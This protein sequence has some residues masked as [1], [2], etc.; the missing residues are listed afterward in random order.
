MSTAS[1]TSTERATAPRPLRL[2]PLGDSITDG[3][4]RL[5]SY[6]YHLYR[7]LAASAHAQTM[8]VGSM[9]GVYDKSSGRNATSGRLVRARDD[10]PVEAQAHEG[11]WGWT[12]RD[13]LLGHPRQPHRGKLSRW[14]QAL[15][16]RRL[17]ADIA[18]VHLG[19]NDLTKLT[20]KHG[21][22]V[23]STARRLKFVVQMLC[24]ASPRVKIALASPIPYCHFA[25]VASR[26]EAQRR[27]RRALEAELGD[28]IRAIVSPAGRP[29]GCARARL[30]YVNMSAAVGCDGLTADRVHPAESG[31]KLM[32]AAWYGAIEPMLAARRTAGA[33]PLAAR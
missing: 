19:T 22:H 1:T 10:W 8:W 12:S 28:R 2:L 3:G 7:L 21:E 24:V 18:L 14:L 30:L 15:G 27:A 23:S 11:H 4:A 29:D 9:A 25:P 26:A 5:R 33:E 6:R 13:V 31:A 17:R 32:A 16:S 20:I